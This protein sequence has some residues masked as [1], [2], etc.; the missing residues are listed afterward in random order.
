MRGLPRPGAVPRPGRSRFERTVRE[1][2][3]A[4]RPT[5]CASGCAACCPL[6]TAPTGDILDAG[7]GSGVFSLE[8]A[9]RH[10]E[11]QVLGIELEPELVDRANEMARRAGLTNCRFRAGR[12][13]QARLRRASSISS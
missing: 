8:L 1:R 7:C 3:S 10:P 9:K 11:A 4:R 13:D 6:P 12:R 5:A 2:C